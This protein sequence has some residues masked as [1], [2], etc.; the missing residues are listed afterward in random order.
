[1]GHTTGFEPHPKLADL[2][3]GLVAGEPSERHPGVEGAFAHC[4]RQFRFRREVHL[5]ADPGGPAPIA[6]LGPGLR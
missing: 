5:V 4:L 3:V 2:P 6:V 1:M